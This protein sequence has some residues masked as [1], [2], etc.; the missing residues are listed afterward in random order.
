[1]LVAG[2]LFD[3]GVVLFTLGTSLWVLVVGRIFLGAAVA[4]ASVA[5][6]LYNSEMAL[7]HIRGR[8]NQI[9][10]ACPRPAPPLS[11]LPF[12]AH[13]ALALCV[14]GR[15]AAGVLWRLIEKCY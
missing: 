13:A 1:M 5:V 3:A 11:Q 2:L 4:F 7:P 14:G 10:Y 6:V 12:A 15:E 9:F 8:L